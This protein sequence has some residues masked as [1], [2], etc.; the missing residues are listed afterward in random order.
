MTNPIIGITLDIEDPGE[1]K[2]SPYVQYYAIRHNYSECIAKHGATPI[3]IPHHTDIID[4]YIDM[5]DGLMVTGG[6]FDIDPKFYGASEIHPEVKIKEGRTENEMA[7]TKAA[8]EKDIPVLG[9]CG[10]EQLLNVVLGGTLIQHIPDESPSDIAHEQRFIS[11][12]TTETSHEINI[13]EDTKLHEIF[14]T[15][16]ISVNSTHHQAVKDLGDNVIASATAPDGIIEAIESTSHKFCLGVQW[17]PEYEINPGETALFK[18][19]VDACV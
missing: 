18:A 9:I 13:A 11:K 10:G 5:I 19:F 3:L 2:F 14:G 12:P 8:L 15:N 4:K 7:L 17:H 6:D 16:S 1:G